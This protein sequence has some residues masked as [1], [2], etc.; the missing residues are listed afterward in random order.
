MTKVAGPL[1]VVASEALTE[2]RGAWDVAGAWRAF[3]EGRGDP[4]GKRTHATHPVA[5][6]VGSL[7]F[8]KKI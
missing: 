7:F 4:L 6:D 8:F 1:T 5:Y 2:V 3:Q